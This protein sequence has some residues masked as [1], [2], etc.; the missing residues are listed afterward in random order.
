MRQFGRVSAW[1][2]GLWS[3]RLFL[4]RRGRR[5]VD[6]K[7]KIGPH[8]ADLPVGRSGL[9]SRRLPAW[10]GRRLFAASNRR[11]VWD[12]HVFW[13]IVRNSWR[14]SDRRRNDSVRDYFCAYKATV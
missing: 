12:E 5:F 13:I 4:M 2:F 14:S 10:P 8:L 6:T 11:T 3:R 1:V 7:I 9:R